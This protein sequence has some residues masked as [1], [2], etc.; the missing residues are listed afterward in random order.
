MGSIYS[1]TFALTTML[2]EYNDALLVAYLATITKGASTINDLI[3]KFNIS[4]E[5]NTRFVCW[6]LVYF[7]FGVCLLP[8]SHSPP[9]SSF[10]SLV[11]PTAGAGSFS[12]M[13]NL[14]PR[15]KGRLVVLK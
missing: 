13:A 5:R 12:E 14:F 2:Q 15:V 1:N 10:L 7:Y 11:V 9:L 4:F 6:G 8:S 3:D